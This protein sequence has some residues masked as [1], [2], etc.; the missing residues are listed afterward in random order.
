MI[1]VYATLTVPA[2]IILESFLSFLG[3]GIQPPTADW[4]AMVRDNATLITFA[5]PTPLYPAAA[6]ALQPEPQFN[7]VGR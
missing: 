6:I 7:I 1:I 4:G 2:V 3:L 5:D